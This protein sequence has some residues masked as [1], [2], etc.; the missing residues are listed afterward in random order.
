MIA[1][2]AIVGGVIAGLV[3]VGVVLLILWG[4]KEFKRISKCQYVFVILS[5]I[6]F[7]KIIFI[8]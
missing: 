6:E 1:V 2:G 8:N 5:E 4:I 7:N 3:G